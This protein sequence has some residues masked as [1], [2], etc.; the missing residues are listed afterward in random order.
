MPGIVHLHILFHLTFIPSLKSKYNYH[1]F[2][3]E[4]NE[5]LERLG[6]WPK[7]TQLL[8]GDSLSDLEAYVLLL[9]PIIAW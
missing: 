2:A 1:H 5:V 9:I 4:E 8:N 7:V 3:D 6:N